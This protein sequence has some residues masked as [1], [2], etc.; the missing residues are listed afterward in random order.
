M[1]SPGEILAGLHAVANDWRWLAAA[2]HLA[3]AVLLLA[4][5]RGW[6]PRASLL[7][8]FLALP[9]ASVAAL[10]LAAAGNPF[11]ALVFG[12]LA[13]ASAAA[14][15]RR[16]ARVV[17]APRGTLAAGLAMIA[18][19]WGYPHFLDAP[20]AYLVAAPMGLIPCPTL[21][22][23]IGFGLV[24][25]GLG[26]RAWSWLLGGAGMLY[27]VVGVLVLGV[28]IDGVLFVG[29]ASLLLTWLPAPAGNGRA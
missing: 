13:V 1:P 20:L 16:Q 2:W 12:A 15:A 18:F 19:G 3:A 22:A 29:A 21:S 4:L 23:V 27:G 11:N 26:S 24:L 7:G 9:L 28:R 17:V 25:G 6:R 14:V 8:W 5:W 10:A